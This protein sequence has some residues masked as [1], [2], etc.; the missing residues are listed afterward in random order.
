MQTA[1]RD[2]KGVSVI[3]YEQTCAT[4]LRRRRGKKLAVDPARRVV[5]NDRVCEG[6]GDCS[7][8]SNCLSVQ[9]LETE[10]GRKRQI[11]QSACNKDFS[12]IKGFCPSF[13]TLE[14]AEVA[15]PKGVTI[16]P[17]QFEQLP[18]PALAP[19]NDCFGLMVTGIG[20]TGVVTISNLIGAAAQA[21]GRVVQALDLT[22]LAQKFGSVQCHLKIANDPEKLKAT[23]LSVGQCDVLIGADIVTSASDDALARFRKDHTVAVV[24]EHEAVT[25]A[26][27]EDREFHLP[28]SAQRAAI[29]R[30]CGDGQVSFVDATELAKKLTGNTIGANMM[31]LGFACQKGWLPVRSA[32]LEAA[33]ETNNVAVRANLEVFR[34]GRLLA[35]DA[36]QVTSLAEKGVAK[37]ASQQLSE[38]VDELI[39]RRAADLAAYQDEAYA[40]RFRDL[41]D[42]VAAREKAV[43][44]AS[45]A[46]TEAVARNYYK[47]LAYKD[48][49]EVARQL[50]D[51]AFLASLKE[52]FSGDFKINFHLAPP[53]LAKIDPISGRPI[54]MAFGPWLLPFLRLLAK[55]KRV[56]GSWLDPFAR[57]AERRAERALID[58]YEATV[59]EILTGLT[60]ASLG[61][62]IALGQW[63]DQIRGYGPVRSAAAGE[64]LAERNKRA[65]DFAN[66]GNR[67]A[68]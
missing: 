14:G 17:A 19:V 5:I 65:A 22:G 39:A 12:C 61:A 6:C 63:P 52:G 16:D 18:E 13:V 46:L 29:E 27:T 1:L 11:D 33:I 67:L 36:A 10:F 42:Q 66:E 3:V 15:K 62:A 48:E 24:N 51:E 44:P 37:R 60:P 41:V 25:G 59:A 43:S 35:H 58:D 9:P 31:L 26:F 49:Y 34:L 23:R 28:I 4:E 8:Q 50:T 54:K 21:E 55:A 68:A 2:V 56:R 7:V 40:A 30:F 47:L 45:T 57:H 38:S 32:S 53:G 20:G 64:A